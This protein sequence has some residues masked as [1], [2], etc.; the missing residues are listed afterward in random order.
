VQGTTAA[1]M[2]NLLAA[3]YAGGDNQRFFIGLADGR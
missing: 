1:A 2:L 3:A